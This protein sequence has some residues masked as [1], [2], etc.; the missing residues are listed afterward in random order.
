MNP[1]DTPEDTAVN[2]LSGLRILELG[3][4]VAGSAASGLLLALGAHVTAAVDSRSPHRH[5]RPTIPIKGEQRSL[6][7]T[8]LDRGKQLVPVDFLDLGAI[9]RLVGGP[10]ATD[11]MFDLVIADR[12]GGFRGALAPLAKLDAYLAF[13]NR[14]NPRSWLTISAFGL[15]GDRRGDTATELTIAAASGMLAS[16]RDPRTGQMLKLP[17]CQSLLSAA[18]AA[19][20]ASCHAVELSAERGRVHLD[21]SATEATIATGPVLDVVG[22]LLDAGSAGEARRYGA[23]AS[24]YPCQDGFIRISAWENHQWQGVVA[25]MGS[26]DWAQR[27]N[28][29]E[30]RVEGSDEV[31]QRVA[32][33]TSGLRKSPTEHLLQSHGVPAA[34]LQTPNDIL[35]SPQLAYRGSF[36]QVLANN[37]VFSIIGAPYRIVDAHHDCPRSMEGSDGNA[38][39]NGHDHVKH[40]PRS[41]RRL[42]VLEAS[43]VLAAPLAGAL[44]GALGADV[45]KIEDTSRLDMYRRNG[46]YIDHTPGANQSAYFAMANHSKR[47]IVLDLETS[48]DQLAALVADSDVVLENLGA[49]RASR[50][51]VSAAQLADTHPHLLSVSSSGFGQDG[52]L[53][54]YRAYA[55]TLHA[56]CGLTYLTRNDNGDLVEMTDLPWA[57]LLS[58]YALATIVAA[59]AIGPSGNDGAA[60]DFAMADLAAAH[61]NEFFAAAAVYSDS[62]TE[63]DSANDLHPFAPNGVYATTD[64]WIAISV[65]GNEQYQQLCII[66]GAS[67][68]SRDEYSS[69]PERFKR[70]RALDALV[71]QAVANRNTAALAHELRRAGIAAE[72]VVDPRDLPRSSQLEFRA[73]FTALVHP[74][75]Q[76]SRVIGLPWRP[77]GEPSMALGRPPDLPLTSDESTAAHPGSFT[78]ALQRLPASPL[79]VQNPPVPDRD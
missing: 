76:H 66:L 18:Q 48:L 64:G 4:G 31:D 27:F 60:I 9:E 50:L 61:F 58:G 16:L 51:S 63:L 59:W 24:L 71:A 32:D 39:V 38:Q 1:S 52:P 73:F 6:L 54:S 43:H 10:G 19:A 53:A 34:A 26:P 30:S 46:P 40:A 49:R 2:F 74:G 25:A 11:P 65:E 78:T 72:E 33:W 68:L 79:P 17:G 70:R 23:P 3:D 47:N 22:V 7:S 55:D 42:K 62:E 41:L 20:L 77:Y 37:T 8:I 36:E 14:V 44:L 28:T 29:L 57:D 45:I 5:A 67:S 35:A 15:S 75:W 13:V 69:A 21:L 12:V 56:W